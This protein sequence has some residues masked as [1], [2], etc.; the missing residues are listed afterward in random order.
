[1]SKNVIK[2]QNPRNISPQGFNVS[3]SDLVPRFNTGRTAGTGWYIVDS[4][5]RPTAHIVC[6]EI[7]VMLAVG[8]NQKFDCI[9][10]VV[11]IDRI[12]HTVHTG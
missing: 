5:F 2:K 7:A 8:C 11:G 9:Y 12:G 3:Y 6:F 10:L 4:D 1:L